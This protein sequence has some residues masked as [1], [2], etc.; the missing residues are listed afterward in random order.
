MHENATNLQAET[1]RNNEDE[2]RGRGTEDFCK[3]NLFAK[4]LNQL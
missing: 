2:K 1:K 4:R 3:T